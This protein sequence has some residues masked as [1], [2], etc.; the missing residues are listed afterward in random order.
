MN[1]PE[2]VIKGNS[3]INNG[4]VDNLVLNFVD[5][6]D[7]DVQRERIRRVAVAAL[8]LVVFGLFV[9]PVVEEIQ[10]IVVGIV[11]NR[12]KV[13]EYFGYTLVN[14]RVVADLLDFNKVGNVDDLVDFTE[15][16]SFGFAI[17][18]NR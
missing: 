2:S 5:E 14:E 6:P 17:L 10:L 18:V 3:P 9:E 8:L 16:P 11:A 1:E 12:G 15:L 7:R 4:L 13:L